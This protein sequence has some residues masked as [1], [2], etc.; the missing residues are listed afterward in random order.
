MFCHA[1]RDLKTGSVLW[2]TVDPSPE[3]C[4]EKFLARVDGLE[5]V[6]IEVVLLDCEILDVV[7]KD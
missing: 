6:D 3:K 2:D 7:D 1:I 5:P 4:M